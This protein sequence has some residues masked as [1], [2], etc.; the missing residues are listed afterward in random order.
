MGYLGYVVDG[1][2]ISDDGEE[3]DGHPLLN[4]G[5]YSEELEV[6]MYFGD[7]GYRL[8]GW[9]WKEKPYGLVEPR[10]KYGLPKKK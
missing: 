8:S 7:K 6:E 2:V 3:Q 4:K 10:I 5:F 9:E 1:R